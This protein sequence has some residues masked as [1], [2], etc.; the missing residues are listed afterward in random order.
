MKMIFKQILF[1]NPEFTVKSRVYRAKYEHK[2]CVYKAKLLKLA[3][4]KYL[5]WN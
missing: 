4:C 2:K 1:E 3:G 5:L